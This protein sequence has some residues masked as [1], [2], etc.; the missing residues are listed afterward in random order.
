MNFLLG[1]TTGTQKGPKMIVKKVQNCRLL[2]AGVTIWTY[3]GK[4]IGNSYCNY[5]ELDLL[6]SALIVH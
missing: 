6:K 3:K 4:K 5:L 1:I 2:C